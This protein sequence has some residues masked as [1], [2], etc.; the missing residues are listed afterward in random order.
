MDKEALFAPREKTTSGFPEDDVPI[1]GVG[2]VRVR[3]LSR[4]EALSMKAVDNAVASERL[5][6]HYAMVDPPMTEAEIGKWQRASGASELE[7]VTGKI[8]E[9]SG[10]TQD[11][12]KEAVKD[13]EANPESEFRVLPSGEAGHD[14]VGTAPEDVS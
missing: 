13:F 8:A 1:P 2:T 9:L 4:F 7:P 5:M 14:G 11:A 10:M 6:L 3:G 12:A